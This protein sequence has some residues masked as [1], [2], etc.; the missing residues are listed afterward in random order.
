MRKAL[1][2]AIGLSRP[3]R[4]EVAVFY[5]HRRLPAPGDPVEGG[6]VKFQRLQQFFPNRPRD[7][8]LLYLGSSSLPG[9]EQAVIRL[10]KR[11]RAP[12]VLNQNGVAYPGWAGAKTAD[13]NDRLRTVLRRADHVVYQSEFCKV[14]ADRFLGEPQAGWEVLHNAVDT[15]AFTP[16]PGPPP[17]GPLILLGGDQTASYRLETALR[18]LALLPD[19]RLLVTGT[20]FDS[21]RALADE[22]GLAARVLFT[23]R[24]A[25]RDAPA[26][27]RRAHLLLHPKVNDP[28]P[29]VVLEAMACGLPVVHSESGGTPELV[30]DAGMG[31]GSDTTWERDVPPAPELLAAAV[32]HVLE[33]LDELRPA[34]RARAERFDF[35]PWVDRHRE[36]FS[37]LV[38]P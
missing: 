27:Y 17:G 14:A 35:A 37:E 29:N 11:R 23:G 33:R 10:A 13:M 28:C 31:V 3:A 1:R 20:V 22:L 34:A 4:G 6:M 38:A 18:T 7:F 8:N 12:I 30:G 25:Q 16:A 24:Y 15:A 9:D 2:A 36:L 21:G 32:E 19:A 26:V 5:G